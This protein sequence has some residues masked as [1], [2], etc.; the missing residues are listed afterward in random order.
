MPL[1]PIAADQAAEELVAVFGDA[2]NQIGLAVEEH[3]FP[4]V[5]VL[6]PKLGLSNPTGFLTG[7]RFDDCASGTMAT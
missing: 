3:V 6:P 2:Q 4:T 1:R 5:A 7:V